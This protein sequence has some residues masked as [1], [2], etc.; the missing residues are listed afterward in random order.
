MITLRGLIKFF[1]V[2]VKTFFKFSFLTK[3]DRLL[4]KGESELLAAFN[5][6]EK[7]IFLTVIERTSEK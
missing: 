1:R 7:F 3:T 4:K 5:R 6:W 2:R